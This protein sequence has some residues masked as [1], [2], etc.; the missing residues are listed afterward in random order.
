MDGTNKC[1]P[2]SP[3]CLV[4]CPAGEEQDPFNTCKC[5]PKDQV[6]VAKDN[7]DAKEEGKDTMAEQK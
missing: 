4:A 2:E 5:L 3:R 7:T 6:D 1:F